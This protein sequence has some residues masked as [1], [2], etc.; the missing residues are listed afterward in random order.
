MRYVLKK[1]NPFLFCLGEQ[2]DIAKV[3][4]NIKQRSPQ[5]S[6]IVDQLVAKFGVHNL[7]EIKSLLA[8][9][10]NKQSRNYSQLN[11]KIQYT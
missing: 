10:I 11:V 4:H 7:D 9:E 2:P 3:V 1:A 5:Y 6:T 8:K